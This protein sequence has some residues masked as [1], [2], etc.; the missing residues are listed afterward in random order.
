[1]AKTSPTQRSLKLLR[2]EGYVAQVVEHFN[3]FA[4]IRQDLWGFIDILA[5]KAGE[6]GL[7]GVQTTSSSNSA[8]RVTKI[9]GIPEHKLW[10]ASGNRICVHGWSK[11]GKAGK[12]KLWQV[13]TTRIE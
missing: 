5:M 9:K 7:L 1:M 12:R 2:G 4:H 11:K 10:L 6:Q 3:I 8:A 13:S